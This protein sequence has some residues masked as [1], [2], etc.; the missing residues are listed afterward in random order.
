[1]HACTD[2]SERV[3]CT[4]GCLHICRVPIQ[5][6]FTDAAL[7]LS[8]SFCCTR[9]C[10]RHSCLLSDDERDT[11]MLCNRWLKTLHEHRVLQLQACGQCR[12]GVAVWHGQRQWGCSGSVVAL[13]ALTTHEIGAA[14]PK[15]V[16]DS[17]HDKQ[18]I[19]QLHRNIAK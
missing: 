7:R 12:N 17:W 5:T 14:I 16:R 18:I 3:C 1:M 19:P 15:P 10:L 2:L 8:T 11:K 13:P 6:A 4:G 9:R